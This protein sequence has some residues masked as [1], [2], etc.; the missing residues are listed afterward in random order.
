[1]VKK[2]LGNN[3]S[4]ANATEQ[5]K[6]RGGKFR[7][8]RWVLYVFIILLFLP[9]L[10][11]QL[12]QVQNYA[13]QELTQY[14][15]DEIGTEVSLERVKLNVF[16]EVRLEKFYIEDLHGDTLLYTGLLDVDHS[17]LYRLINKELE[18]ESLT[19][20]DAN[21]TISREA[22]EEFKNYQFLVD[23]FTP[24]K[25]DQQIDKESGP[26]VLN[27]GHILLTNVHFLTPDEV[28]GET[29]EVDVD[30]VEAFIDKFDLIGGDIHIEKLDID[31]PN[32]KL[33]QYERKP[34][35]E[36]AAPAQ[37]V[38]GGETTVQPDTLWFLSKTST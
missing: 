30:R 9:V 10:L 37:L 14:L 24:E 20:A 21:I 23:Y 5:K 13:A 15:S 32:V 2:T 17:G 34:I 4:K 18:I 25:K 12:P 35:S 33:D 19:L 28:K 7:W 11:F 38:S 36:A 3:D 27:L 6:K 22:G 29:I 26:F 1:M 31:G 8:L 16:Y